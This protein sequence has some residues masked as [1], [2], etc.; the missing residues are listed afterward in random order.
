MTNMSYTDLEIFLN[1]VDCGT[2]SGAAERLYMSQP[3]LTKHLQNLE[4]RLAYPLFVR[5]RGHRAIRLTEQGLLFLPVARRWMQLYREADSIGESHHRP[6]LHLASIGS[7]G[8][9]ILRPLISELLVSDPG[10]SL[11]YHFCRSEEG[12]RLIEQGSCEIA[13]V[14]HVRSQGSIDA[15]SVVLL[16]VGT[17]PFVL[18]SSEALSPSESVPVA[19]ENLNAAHEVRLPWNISFDLWHTACFPADVP[20]MVRLDQTAMLSAFLVGPAF[21]IVPQIVSATVLEEHPSL[22]VRHLKNG[23]PEE[24][25]YALLPADYA[26]NPLTMHFLRALEAKLRVLPGIFP[27]LDIASSF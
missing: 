3:A 24:T 20:P 13:L 15:S 23:P 6:V 5:Q 21:A 12:Y 19:V 22:Q 18:I 4:E 9:G 16:P 11:S 10:Y 25:Y 27:Q 2:L 8:A 26:E 14:D 7:V 17:C 1:L